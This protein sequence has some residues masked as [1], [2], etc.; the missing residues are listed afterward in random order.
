MSSIA[1]IYRF[2]NSRSRSHCGPIITPSDRLSEFVLW[3][4]TSP[5]F[6][7]LKFLVPSQ[8]QWRS[9][10]IWSPEYC[11]VIL[12]CSCWQIT[13]QKPLICS[14]RSQHGFYK[15]WTEKRASGASVSHWGISWCLGS[16][17][18]FTWVL[19][20]FSP[21]HSPQHVQMR[22]GAQHFC[23]GSFPWPMAGSQTFPT[24]E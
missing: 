16:K 21:W 3:V 18:G 24:E 5:G 15:I 8:G 14:I 20:P 23:W 11:L 12:Y 10:Q 19:V 6:G 17:E 9:H 1:R 4:P 22:N 2:R 13:W 7:A